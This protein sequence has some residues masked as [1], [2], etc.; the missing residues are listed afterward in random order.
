MAAIQQFKQAT[1]ETLSNIIGETYTGLTNAEIHRLLLESQ[2]DDDVHPGLMISKHT[3]L[4][5]AFTSELSKHHYSNNIVAFLQLFLDPARY[6]GQAGLFESRRQAVNKQLA[7]EGLEIDETG[8]AVLLEEKAN[9]LQDIEIRVKGLKNKLEQ[10]NAHPAIAAYC[11][12]EL[13]TD[14][15]FHAVLEAN[16]GLFQRIRDISGVDTDGI[17]LIE[18]VFSN[19]PVVIINNYITSSEKNEHTGFCN[20]LKGLCS[21]FRNPLAHEPKVEWPMSEQDALEILSI[22][23]YCHRRLDNA[24]RIRIA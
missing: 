21:M 19:N 14:N 6:V 10:R 2:I 4:Y 1:I 13:L 7:F 11:R 5:N 8:H 17:A 12:A 18:Q 22:I 24:H 23:S 16:K 3:R 9:R 20:L 15:Y